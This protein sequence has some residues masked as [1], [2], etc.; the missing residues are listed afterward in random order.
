MLPI[1]FAILLSRD[2][3][4]QRNSTKT[5]LVSRL[6]GGKQAD[7]E[8]G[9]IWLARERSSEPDREPDAIWLDLATAEIWQVHAIGK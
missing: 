9:A 3:S 1:P 7:L 6:I 2:K 5:D 8:I 4:L